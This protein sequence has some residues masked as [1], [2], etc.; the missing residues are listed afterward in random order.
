[1]VVL[2]ILISCGSKEGAQQTTASQEAVPAADGAKIFKLNCELCHGYDGKLGANGSK[3]LSISALSLDE[4]I[5]IITK[6]KGAMVAYENILTL[7]EIKAVAEYTLT[8]K[9]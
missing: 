8:L 4:R 6:G 9:K 1:M 7:S 2:F 5:A 3:D